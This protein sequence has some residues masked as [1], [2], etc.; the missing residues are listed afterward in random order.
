VFILLV[1]NALQPAITGPDT[2]VVGGIVLIAT[3]VGANA[4]VS[5]FDRAAVP[6]PIRRGACGDH[7]GWDVHP[8]RDEA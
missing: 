8:R 7:Q 6:Q 5:R 3:L 1:A 2:S 4:L